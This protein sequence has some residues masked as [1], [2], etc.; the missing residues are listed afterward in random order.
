MILIL[1]LIVTKTYIYA[2]VL[3]YR[4]TTI[5]KPNVR[6]HGENIPYRSYRSYRSYPVQVIQVIQIYVFRFSLYII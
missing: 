2:F 1:L 3:L 4:F 6:P 5:N